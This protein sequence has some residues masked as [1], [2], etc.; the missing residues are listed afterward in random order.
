MP[1]EGVWLLGI[2]NYFGYLNHS[3]FHFSQII[4]LLR[5]GV[6]GRPSRGPDP[7]PVGCVGYAGEYDR[8][9]HV[10]PWRDARQ[11]QPMV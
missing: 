1:P 8:R 3:Y 4:G 6:G 11:S 2:L 10:G 9:L 7:G 5:D